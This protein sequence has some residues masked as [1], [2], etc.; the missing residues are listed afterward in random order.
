MENC[1]DNSGWCF[2]SAVGSNLPSYF[3]AWDLPRNLNAKSSNASSA[4]SLAVKAIE[5]IQMPL[6]Q[7][8]G[9]SSSA[10]AGGTSASAKAG[11]AS[12]HKA[13]SEGA[14][15][16][17]VQKPIGANAKVS[18]A[19]TSTPTS[20]A[21]S[22][23]H[24]GARVGM[25]VKHPAQQKR[26]PLGW[27]RFAGHGSIASRAGAKA[28]EEQAKPGHS[29]KFPQAQRLASASSGISTLATDRGESCLHC[30]SSSSTSSASH[31]LTD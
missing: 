21:P 19:S 3:D 17:A 4:L 16:G 29:S 30:S 24:D 27:H 28:R 5:A 25:I 11:V 18:S 15:V 1:E 22:Y 9:G 8:N 31:R 13:I 26:Q 10:S 14:R 2:Q 20:S 6:S 12:A 7:S 23:A